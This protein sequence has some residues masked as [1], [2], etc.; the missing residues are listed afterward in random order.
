[1]QTQVLSILLVSAALAVPA[2]AADAPG[3]VFPNGYREWSH[4][5]SAV[6]YSD[7]HP[8]FSAFGG[9]HHIYVNKTGLTAA[10]Q[11]AKY[12]DGSILVFDLLHNEDADGAYVE[13]ARKVVAVM[14]KN[15]QKYKATGG[16][17]YQAFKAG[18]AA[19]PVVT[20]ATTQ[21][22][23]CHQSRKDNDFVFSRFR[24]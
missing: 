15:A 2:M 5:K 11:G 9:I 19:E 20:D 10:K 23:A 3:P 7:K 8:L 24:D 22:F 4:V 13:G 16:W 12:P 6:I 1:L 21:C 18:N 14:Q 17:G